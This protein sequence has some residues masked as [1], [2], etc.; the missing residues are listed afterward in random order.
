MN[1]VLGFIF[2]AIGFVVIWKSD[3]L[4]ENIGAIEFAEEK[5][6]SY[7]GTKFFFKLIG[8]AIIILAF[9]FMGGGLGTLLRKVFAPK[10]PMG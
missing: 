4:Y 2:I 8:V 3:W 5:L 7:G 9:L 1:Y 10:A 6:A